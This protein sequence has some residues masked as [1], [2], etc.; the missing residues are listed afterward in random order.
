MSDD[1]TVF[2]FKMREGLKW[3]DGEPVTTEDVRFAGEHLRQREALSEWF[4][5]ARFRTGFTPAGDPMTL[6]II[7]DYNFTLTSSAPY[8]GFLRNITIEGWNGYTELINP[9]HVL[10]KWHID[11]AHRGYEGGLEANNL[12]EWWT[13]VQ[14]AETLPGWDVT[15]PVASAIPTDALGF[16]CQR[17]TRR[18]DLRS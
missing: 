15:A 4:L 14:P 16:R 12:T 11:F 6:D 3:S 7:D 9:A 8:G 2:T 10:K 5:P 18:D 1:N 13:L 17:N